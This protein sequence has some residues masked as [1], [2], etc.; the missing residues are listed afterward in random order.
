VFYA[1]A[2]IG[3]ILVTVNTHYRQAELEYLLKQS[4]ADYLFLMESYRGYNYLEALYAIAPEIQASG[5]DGFRAAA[6][7][8]L[9]KVFYL[10]EEPQPGLINFNDILALAGRTPLAEF[11][12]VQD[13]LHYDQVINMQYTSGTTGFPKGVTLSHQN[14]VTNGYWGGVQQELTCDDRIC[15]PVPLF[16]CFGLVLGAL[17]ALNHGSAV[18]VLN[19]YSAFDILAQVEKEKCTSIYGVPSVFIS[20]LEQKGFDGFDL[21][22]L[23]TGI[24]AGSPCPVKTMREV[25]DR[26]HARDITICYGLTETSPGVAQTTKSDS[27]ARRTETVGR[28]LPGVEIKIA[29]STGEALPQGKIGEVLVRGYIV[30]QGY[31]N[32]PEATAAI[33]TEDGYLRTG[34]LGRVDEDG[35]LSITGR[36]KDMIIRAGEN[37]YPQEVEEYLRHMPGVADVQIVAVPSKLHG[38][39]MGAFIVAVPG[40]EDIDVKSVKAYLRPLISGYKIPRHVK[41]LDK[42]PLTGS[43][44]VQ[45]F[46]LREM[47][48]E[49]WHKG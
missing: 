10:G 7:P 8:H 29:A 37:I 39:E 45:K 32:Q 22:S 28:A 5:R 23:R 21:S 49:L 15:L 35:Y 18:V 31:Y 9:K 41:V 24:M 16:H 1:T 20:L 34:D 44:K 26:M 33:M 3:A 30:M 12:A 40:H 47:A 42:F 6:L 36:G 43:G 19:I 27:L 48:A 4:E 38:E 11:R 13:A 46:K 2:K 14:I 17:A 25:I